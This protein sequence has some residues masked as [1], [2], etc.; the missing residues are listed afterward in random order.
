MFFVK[1]D[2]RGVAQPGTSTSTSSEY[3]WPSR[4]SNGASNA[5]GLLVETGQMRYLSCQIGPRLD[6]DLAPPRTLPR[7]AP[8]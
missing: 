1:N 2:G 5:A 3:K 7:P 4:A 8:G 6:P